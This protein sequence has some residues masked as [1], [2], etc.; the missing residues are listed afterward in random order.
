MKHIFGG[1]HQQIGSF[2][3]RYHQQ[4]G[5]ADVE[6]RFLVADLGGQQPPGLRGQGALFGN[7][8]EQPDIG[9]KP[10]RYRRITRSITA[11]VD[12]RHHCAAQHGSRCVVGV[13][14]ELRRQLNQLRFAERCRIRLCDKAISRRQAA[15]HGRRGGPETTGMRN[16]VAA[17]HH[18]ATCADPRGLQPALDG[19]HHQVFRAPRHLVGALTV[20][21]H[22]QAGIRCLDHDLVAQVQ[23]QTDAVKSRAEVGAGRRYHGGGHEAGRQRFHACR[24]AAPG[25]AALAIA[26]KP[27]LASRRRA[28]D[29]PAARTRSA[30]PSARCRDP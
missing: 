15:D 2:G 29:P 26:T 19:P 10:Q 7:R 8:E 9:M 27:A 17:A 25:F 23:C 12:P 18:Q 3:E 1:R 21:L 13:A 24:P 20:D 22:N 11:S 30:C 5:T 28:L 6:P 4:R 14:L 16:D